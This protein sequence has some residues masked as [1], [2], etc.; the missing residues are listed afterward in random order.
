MLEL[1]RVIGD[2]RVLIR[3]LAERARYINLEQLQGVP[4]ME[5]E[6]G[7]NRNGNNNQDINV[8]RRN[9][10]EINSR[11]I[12]KQI[13]HPELFEASKTKE[14]SHIYTIYDD[15]LKTE[16]QAKLTMS[17][18]CSALHIKVKTNRSSE[19]YSSIIS[20]NELWNYEDLIDIWNRN[21]EYKVTLSIRG[22]NLCIIGYGLRESLSKDP[23]IS[24]TNS[25]KQLKGIPSIHRE[26]KPK[27][28]Q[29]ENTE[30]TPSS[31][32]TAKPVKSPNSLSKSQKTPPK[33][34]V[35]FLAQQGRTFER[36]TVTA[37]PVSPRSTREDIASFRDAEDEENSDQ[38][39]YQSTVG[40]ILKPVNDPVFSLC[41]CSIST[42]AYAFDLDRASSIAVETVGSWLEKHQDPR[43]RIFLVDISESETLKKFRE[44]SMER[45]PP[46]GI[47]RFE[48]RAANIVKLKDEGIPC[49]YI[50]NASN[51]YF[52]SG[53]SGTNKA[54][55]RA[56]KSETTTLEKLTL[57]YYK[58]PAEVAQA[59][60]VDLVDGVP[61]KDQQS[62]QTVIHVVGPN[63]SNKRVNSLKGD[64]EKG[65]ILL[66]QSYNGVLSVFFHKIYRLLSN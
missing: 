24:K 21:S 44:K 4:M 55:H 53:G 31:T 16:V 66:R 46:H 49:Y 18:G 7:N 3:D 27:P 28:K 1:K 62:V 36:N 37:T 41:L 56:C 63:M 2:F 14:F 26:T 5:Q 19:L 48:I 20:V 29:P 11:K 59:Y 58:I 51:P 47:P 22:D 17:L 6:Y 54:I 52:K 9:N 38:Q 15:N 43:I 32:P 45:Y 34:S 50:V 60:P 39:I 12:P 40:P 57:K 33:P 35:P 42:A 8:H 30:T 65:D 25:A 61:L 13:S 23:H 10:D 64:Y